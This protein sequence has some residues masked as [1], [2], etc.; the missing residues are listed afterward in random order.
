[1]LSRQGRVQNGNLVVLLGF[2]LEEV[3]NLFKVEG[4]DPMSGSVPEGGEVEAVV[5][6]DVSASLIPPKVC[7][8]VGGVNGDEGEGPGG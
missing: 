8:R 2:R 6:H 7:F 1:M 3:S 5:R 4:M